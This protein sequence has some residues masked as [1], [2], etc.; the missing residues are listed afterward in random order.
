MF[1]FGK[2]KSLR[3]EIFA[4]AKM[5]LPSAVKFLLTQK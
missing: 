3:G 2:M 5:K 1:A 4:D